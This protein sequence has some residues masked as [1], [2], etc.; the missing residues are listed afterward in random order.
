MNLQSEEI[1]VCMYVKQKVLD[2]AASRLADGLILV[3]EFNPGSR[4]FV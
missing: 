4:S 2:P 1:Y 3:S